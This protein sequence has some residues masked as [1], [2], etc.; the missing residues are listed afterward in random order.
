M[1]CDRREVTLAEELVELSG[2]QGALDKDDDLVKLHIVKKLVE[3]AVLLLLI[4]LDVVL[5]KTVQ[6]ELGVVINVN[7]KR[8]LHELLADRADFLG[9]GGAEH[10]DLLLGWGGAEDLLDVAAHVWKRSQYLLTLCAEIY[11]TNLIEH[12]VTLIEDEDL[13][14]SETEVLVTD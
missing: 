1:N 13:D 4:K 12:L 14:A 7:L 9:Q 5:L 11:H 8:V 3:L 10:H 2:A 6:G